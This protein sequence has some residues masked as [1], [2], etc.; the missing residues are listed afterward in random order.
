[1]VA[2][3]SILIPSSVTVFVLLIAWLAA[4]SQITLMLDRFF[5]V[6]EGPVPVG[7]YGLRP[8]EFLIGPRRWFLAKN[9]TIVPDSHRR[10]TVTLD[11][12]SFT[13]GPVTKHY[14]SAIPEY[15][16]TPDPDDQISFTKSRSRLSWPTPFQWNLVGVATTSW[17]RH[18]YYRL[19]WKKS[20]GAML[21]LVWRDEQGFYS[22]QG[23]RDGNLQIAPEVKITT[24]P[25]EDVVVRYVTSQKAWKREEYHLESRGPSIDGKYD[26]TAIILLKDAQAAHPGAGQSVE[27]FV[28][29]VSGQVSKELGGQ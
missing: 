16:F 10:L 12:R 17:R 1:M 21:E 26:I 2:V 8:D 14:T 22:G 9:L 23:W 3:R 4:G 28:D 15:E 18:S 7:Q 29:K 11:G 19:L 5:T 20:S 24:S 6:P 13:L 25:F 27:V